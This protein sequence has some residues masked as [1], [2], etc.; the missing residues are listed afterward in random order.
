MTTDAVEEAR[1]P[2]LGASLLARYLAL[3]PPYRLVVRWTLIVACVGVAFL[4][5]IVNVAHTA[6]VGGAGG[7]V[8]VVPM[9]AILAAVGVAR[10]KRTELPIHDRQTDII[11]GSMGLVLVLLISG[12]LLPRFSLY[13]HLLRLDLFA[14]W[15]FVLSA[16]VLLFGLRPVLRFRYVWALLF[17]VFSLPYHLSVIAFGGG[18]FA[19]G[20]STM[21]I[22]GVATGIAVGTSIRRGVTGSLYAWA[23]GFVVLVF[24][25][26]AFTDAPMLVYQEVPVLV[27]ITLVG[28]FMYFQARRGMPKKL[29]ER[30]VEPLAAQQVWSGV[31]PV[32]GVALILA[33]IPLPAGASDTQLTG[34]AP[35]VLVSGRP[36]AVPPG[37]TETDETRYTGMSRFFA[38]NSVLLRQRITADTGEP[39]FDKLSRPRTVVVDNIVSPRPFTFDVY[40]GRVIYNMTGARLSET[41]PIDLGYGVVGQLLSVV[42]DNL[43]VTWNSL[44]FTWGDSRLA[45]RVSMFA[46]DNHDP[47]APFPEPTTNMALTL[48][49]MFTLLL[50]GNAVLDEKTPSFKD[51]QLLTEFGR[52]L[53][54]AQFTAGEPAR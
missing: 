34:A 9:A 2:S 17:M 8:W 24:I 43:R 19:A 52:A 22:A 30:K 36:L 4:D 7:Y 41:R 26:A 6:Y 29:F 51:A 50:R 40:P 15:L 49:T 44:R 14:M 54:A 53:V 46:V 27:S 35:G 10:R 45:Q 23:V 48:R 13:F 20:A 11:V 38:E 1:A 5:S 39:R 28:I 31:P 12:V 42:D 3:S 21:V 37:W 32:V 33:F 18:K 16:S 25:S 47:G